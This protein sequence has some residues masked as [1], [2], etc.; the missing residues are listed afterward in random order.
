MDFLRQHQAQ[1]LKQPKQNGVQNPDQR[2]SRVLERITPSSVTPAQNDLSHLLNGRLP[3]LPTTTSNEQQLLVKIRANQGPPQQN[4]IATTTAA[5]LKLS[6]RLNNIAPPPT[7]TTPS[8]ATASKTVQIKTQQQPQIIT[9][10]GQRL[11]VALS[12]VVQQQGGQKILAGVDKVIVLNGHPN[13][14]AIPRVQVGP[15]GKIIQQQQH[16]VH[17]PLPGLPPRAV[18]V[19]QPQAQ[20]I[21]TGQAGGREIKLILPQGT[22]V[23]SPIKI[24]GAAGVVRQV[25]TAGQQRVMQIVTPSGH[26]VQ[27]AIGGVVTGQR[28][29]VQSP[30]KGLAGVSAAVAQITAPLP[31]IVKNT[32]A[33]VTAGGGIVP[34]EVVAA[35]NQAARAQAKGVVAVKSPVVQAAP[36][37]VAGKV[38]AGSGMVQV[39]LKSPV[40]S[41]AGKSPGPVQV[42]VKSP[43]ISAAPVKME[44]QSTGTSQVAGKSTVVS[45][46]Q[47]AAKSPVVA[48][49]ATVV[50]TAQGHPS[51]KSP[52]VT[53][54]SPVVS[55]VPVK[56]ASKSSAV[57]T[58]P[59]Q[60]AVKSAAVTTTPTQIAVKSPSVTTTPAQ[61][62]HLKL[63]K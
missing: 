45:Y 32:P 29:P 50:S 19:Q 54:K 27:N 41:A 25:A 2:L 61:G 34:S 31:V 8:G 33:T 60:V 43:V 59:V 39:S 12:N 23:G 48:V 9:P 62:S 40:V 55:T 51:T 44:G 53:V 49:K 36:V 3:P 28:T 16:V 26:V 30:V 11:S 22:P 38:P 35:R 5:S 7:T 20:K 24:A 42:A 46:A 10:N 47:V 52:T 57:T 63:L 17:Q 21:V 15:G 13:T 37:Q 1:M 4:G 18:V 6:E 14:N 56:V 58:A